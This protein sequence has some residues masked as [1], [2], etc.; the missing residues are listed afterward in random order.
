MTERFLAKINE[1][2]NKISELTARIEK[3]EAKMSHE[4]ELNT[5]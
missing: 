3:L 1:Q 2:T 5:S 4:N